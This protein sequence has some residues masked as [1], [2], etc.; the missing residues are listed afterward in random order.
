M[1]R[2]NAVKKENW[3]LIDEWYVSPKFDGTRISM[4]N[5]QF[6]LAHK[7]KN[8]KIGRLINAFAVLPR[9]TKTWKV[10]GKCYYCEAKVEG[11]ILTFINM[12]KVD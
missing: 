2:K 10:Y 4:Y 7:C 5:L 11:P 12:A 8:G 3:A 9:K 6:Y 1:H